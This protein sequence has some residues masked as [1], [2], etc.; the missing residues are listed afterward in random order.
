VCWWVVACLC[1][2]LALVR[3]CRAAACCAG[4]RG[5]PCNRVRAIARLRCDA[6][7][8]ALLRGWCTP[9]PLARLLRLAASCL[10]VRGRCASTARALARL[11][12]EAV[13]EA[14][15]LV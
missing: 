11:D 13:R 6:D 15:V 9:R 14:A 1:A 7:R 2:A 8:W 5:R 12:A 10:A 4:V 3:L